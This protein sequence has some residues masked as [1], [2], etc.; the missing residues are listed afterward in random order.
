MLK[1]I[2]TPDEA[3]LFNTH[4]SESHQFATGDSYLYEM[5][6]YVISVSPF[7]SFVLLIRYN[8]KPFT[9]RRSRKKVYWYNVPDFSMSFSV[10]F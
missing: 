3:N 4:A 5:S 7:S 9:V 1:F 10:N 2:P 8:K 6:K